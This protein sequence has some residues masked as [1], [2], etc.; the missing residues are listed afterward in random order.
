MALL[1]GTAVAAGAAGA[2]VSWWRAGS[3]ARDGGAEIW[4]LQF[5]R[6]D[7]TRLVLADFRG[8]PLLVNFWATWCPPCIREL[9]LIDRFLSDQQARGWQ[10]VGIAV[11]Q[12]DPVRKFLEQRPVGFGVGLA[13]IEGVE[14]SRR[15]GNAGGA[16]PFSVVFDRRGDVV[17]RK[18]GVI[19]P[20]DLTRWVA[21]VG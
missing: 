14:L 15:M 2:G 10:V 8:K 20:E 1:A 11:D 9:P 16:L 4:S 18:L 5:D 19:L 13:G 17:Q 7:G 3:P 12:L 21:T 6:P